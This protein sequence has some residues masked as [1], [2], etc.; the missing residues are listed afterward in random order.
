MRSGCAPAG[1]AA[2]GRRGWAGAHP[3]RTWL[4]VR[5]SDLDSYGH[6]NNVKFYDYVQEARVAIM[7]ATLDWSAG[8]VGDL[9]VTSSPSPVRS[10]ASVK[11]PPTSTPRITPGNLPSA[12]LPQAAATTSNSS[13]RCLC[14]GQYLLPGSGTRWHE[15]PR[16]V[17]AWLSLIHI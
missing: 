4:G 10:A 11:V 1:D 7:T 13:S 8:V 14:D 5:W 15:E 12:A 6:V 2:S 17:V 16:R 3:L 9:A